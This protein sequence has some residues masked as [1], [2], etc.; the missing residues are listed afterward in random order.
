MDVILKMGCTGQY[1]YGRVAH[2]P[3]ECAGTTL[4]TSSKGH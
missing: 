3:R 1:S 4:Q 2:P